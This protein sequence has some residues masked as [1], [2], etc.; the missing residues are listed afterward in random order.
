MVSSP[1]PIPRNTTRSTKPEAIGEGDETNRREEAWGL[2]SRPW[3]SQGSQPGSHRPFDLPAESRPRGLNEREHP[4]R[5]SRATREDRT[6]VKPAP[7]RRE[8]MRE[9]QS[10]R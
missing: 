1:P 5:Q 3:V 2:H 9:Y 8:V 6:S 4:E 10:G 7:L